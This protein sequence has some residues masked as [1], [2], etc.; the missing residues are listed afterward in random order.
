MACLSN[1]KQIINIVGWGGSG[2]SVLH[3]LLDG[4]P[5]ILSDPIHTKI[6]DGFVSFN[7]KNSAHKDIRTLRKHL[8]VR[9]YYNIEAIAFK[10]FLSI[11]LSSKQED[12]IT[13]P[14]SFD[15][16]RFESSWVERLSRL[17]KWSA[18]LIIS[19]LYEEYGKELNLS[20]AINL[21]LE[22]SSPLT[23][24]HLERDSTNVQCTCHSQ[25]PEECQ[26]HIRK[27]HARSQYL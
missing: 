4:H 21:L 27:F 25:S 23:Q 13:I 10:K 15:F 19:I 8:E 20:L 24:L 2:K 7:E 9:G 12:I 1:K 11:P 18:D 14:F 26:K 17:E 5:E 6:V 22:N 16:Y 3:S